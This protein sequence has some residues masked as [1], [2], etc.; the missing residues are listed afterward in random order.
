MATTPSG[1]LLF[2]GTNGS[3][4]LNDTWLFNDTTNSWSQVSTSLTPPARRGHAMAA[5]PSGDV[6]LFGGLG[7]SLNLFNDTWLFDT[8]T[9]SWSQVSTSLTPP[10]RAQHAMAAISSGVLL[11]GGFDE[12]DSSN[13]LSDTWLFNTATNSWSQVSASS[14]PS[15]RHQT[16]MVTTPQGALLFGGFD[17]TG[18]LN[19]TWLFN[20]SSKTWSLLS[21]ASAPSAR[22]SHA[23]A[24]TPS[25]GVLLF[26]GFIPPTEPGPEGTPIDDTWFFDIA[27]NTW[28]PVSTSSAPPAR[29]GHA[30]TAT[31]AGVL[32]F[33]GKVEFGPAGIGGIDDTWR[34]GSSS[35]SASPSPSVSPTP[36]RSFP[37]V[38]LDYW[39][40]PEIMSLVRGG[41]I[42]GY[43]DGAFK[44]EFPVTRAEFAKMALLSLGYAQEFP[45]SPSFPDVAKEEWYYGYVEGAVMHGLVKGYPDSTFQPQGNITITEILTVCVRAQGW[46][47]V[48]PPDP[49]PYILLQDQDDSVRAITADDWYYGTVGA[50]AQYGLLLFPD[51]EQIM[52][53]GGGSSEYEVRF[54]AAASRAQTAIFL[55]RMRGVP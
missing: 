33:G 28:S 2:G 36:A 51:K 24:T 18:F 45:E 43:P 14:A 15:G 23:M 26:G 31:P 21:T 19:D 46:E 13:F 12:F 27:T 6:L 34:Y 53:A 49:P 47:E 50:A 8:T 41:V 4:Y 32:L 44:P 10:A 3:F 25:G 11:F 42:N 30:M 37:D 40:Y 39:A 9:N 7:N 38:P 1:V 17:G 35:P 54:N 16:S 52:T 22:A 55:A 29:Y 20:A 5:T 48:A